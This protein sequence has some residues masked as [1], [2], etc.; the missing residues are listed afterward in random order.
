MTLAARLDDG[1]AQL[2]FIRMMLLVYKRQC[3]GRPSERAAPRVDAQRRAIDT[4]PARS[5][6]W[7][8]FNAGRR[9]AIVP[10]RPFCRRGAGQLVYCM[11]VTRPSNH[12]YLLLDLYPPIGRPHKHR[13]A[14]DAF[15]IPHTSSSRRTYFQM[16][17]NGSTSSFFCGAAP[18]NAPNP[19]ADAVPLPADAHGSF[20]GAAPHRFA[21]DDAGC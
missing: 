8:A 21:P 15:S 13:S 12:V 18:P 16:F 17:A 4:S 5:G 11:Q 2:A 19:P 7:I 9:Q 10:H 1:N 3:I 14:C 20:V 6:Y